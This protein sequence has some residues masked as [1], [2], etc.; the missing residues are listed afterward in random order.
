MTTVDRSKCIFLSLK[1]WSRGVPD[2][3]AS[4]W[5]YSKIL[6]I[7]SQLDFDTEMNIVGPVILL[8][9][10]VIVFRIMEFSRNCGKLV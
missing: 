5:F 1:V 9:V 10:Q 4:A 2:A 3:D 8:T 6:A 7:M